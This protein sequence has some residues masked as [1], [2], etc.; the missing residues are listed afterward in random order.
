VQNACHADHVTGHR[1]PAVGGHGVRRQL[2]VVGD[3]VI[4]QV[5]P[6]E[7]MKFHRVGSRAGGMAQQGQGTFTSSPVGSGVSRPCAEGHGSLAVPPGSGSAGNAQ[8]QLSQ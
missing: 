2:G 1:Q 4:A 7:Q 5:V 6:R 3:A 8:T